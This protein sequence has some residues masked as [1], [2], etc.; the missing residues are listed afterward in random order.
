[1]F[2]LN[3]TVKRIIALGTGAA[4]LGA[5]VL[6]AM[7]AADLSAYPKPFVD[8]GQFNGLVVVGANAIGTDTLGAADILASLQAANTVTQ[9]I[10][11]TTEIV[12]EGGVKIET[13]AKHLY[14]G[15]GIADVK[16]TFTKAEF[17]VLL[18]Q[19]TLTGDD[20]TDY[21]YDT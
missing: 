13:S 15:D 6:G 20:G 10:S 21:T 3:K 9:T 5:T 2:S 18:K 7:A 12:V 8:N 14:L 11:G 4:M 17:P 16:T 1:M 19:N